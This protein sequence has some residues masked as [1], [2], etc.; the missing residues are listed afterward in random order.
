[1]PAM[2]DCVLVYWPVRANM[3]GRD[4][5]IEVTDVPGQRPERGASFRLALNTEASAWIVSWSIL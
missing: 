1:M 3:G 4:Y 2:M 5:G